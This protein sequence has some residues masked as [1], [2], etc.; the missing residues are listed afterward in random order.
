M[1]DTYLRTLSSDQPQHI[2]EAIIKLGES[3]D[4]KAVAPLVRALLRFQDH[5]YFKALTCDALGEI[6]DLRATQALLSQLRDP[7][8]EVRESAF[9]AL[10]NIGERRANAMP[11]AD[12][13][14]NGFADPN[15]ALTQ[16]AWQ[17]DLEAVQLLLKALDEEDTEVKV[18][19]L[20]T[21][22]QLG[23]VGALSQI[24]QQLNHSDDN[25]GAAA[26]FALGELARLGSSQT[27]H[28]VCQIL[29]Q[30]WQSP[31]LGL[32]AQIQVL[33]AAAECHTL[34]QATQHI[35]AQIFVS[36]LEHPESI[37]RQLAVIGLGRLGDPRSAS[38]LELRLRD[39]DIGVRRNAA[40]ALGTISAA[41]SPYIL[42]RNSIDQPSEVRVAILQV[43]SRSLREKSLAAVYEALN[44]SDVRYRAASAYLLGG[45]K[46]EKGLSKTLQD[47]DSTV[48]KNSALAVGSAQLNVLIPLLVPMLND[49]EWRVRA[50]AAEGLKRLQNPKVIPSLKGR[51][52]VESHSVVISALD[53]SISSLTL[54][55]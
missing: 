5:P 53:S 51:R 4:S 40:Y 20:Y 17:T 12:T 31:H 48:R 38:L 44:S 35:L 23:F 42:V 52:E 39:S 7:S 47:E 28:S 49:S 19:A 43:L 41:D 34:D 13:W 8:D 32:E 36:S 1:I 22:G 26:A 16:I 29:H 33:R 21:L 18:G 9:S 10:F 46:D 11:D 25:V 50:A 30:A 14:E 24:A 27:A 6:G 2:E 3:R 37:L 54:S 15:E 55:S 45:L